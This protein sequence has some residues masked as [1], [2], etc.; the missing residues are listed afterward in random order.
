MNR[1]I[2]A[3]TIYEVSGDDLDYLI[4]HVISLL[5]TI[6]L[7]GGGGGGVEW[8]HSIPPFLCLSVLHAESTL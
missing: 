8:F 3:V 2:I 1:A 7:L 4:V 6:K 5:Y